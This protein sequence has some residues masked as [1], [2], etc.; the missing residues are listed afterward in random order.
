MPCVYL[1]PARYTLYIYLYILKINYT[2][3]NRYNLYYIMDTNF[4]QKP[5]E[6]RGFQIYFF[7][8]HD[9]D[10]S[11][12]QLENYKKFHKRLSKFFQMA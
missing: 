9:F 11:Y 10:R 2:I 3:L 1:Y 7:W 8:I 5:L 4:T 6:S 12:I